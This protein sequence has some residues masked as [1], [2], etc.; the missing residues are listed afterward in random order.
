MQQYCSSPK[1]ESCCSLALC[2][3][4]CLE[5]EGEKAAHGDQYSV[6]WLSRH[7]YPCILFPGTN[8]HRKG[9]NVYCD[10][11]NVVLPFL[12]ALLSIRMH[13]FYSR[14]ITGIW[15]TGWWWALRS[16]HFWLIH[17]PSVPCT[18]GEFACV[19]RPKTYCWLS[20][21]LISNYNV[22]WGISS[23]TRDWS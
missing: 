10:P 16:D 5:E 2:S 15:R 8:Q 1:F 4:T 18:A 6:T 17:W 21:N 14:D 9:Q 23:W 13:M 3:M 20:L 19:V 11:S 12:W 22:C 7:L